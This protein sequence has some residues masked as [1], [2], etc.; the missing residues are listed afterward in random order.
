MKIDATITD[1]LARWEMQGYASDDILTI[2]G[3]QEEKPYYLEQYKAWVQSIQQR[4][5][6]AVG[7][8]YSPDPKGNEVY[9]VIAVAKHYADPELTIVVYF[10]MNDPECQTAQYAMLDD[11]ARRQYLIAWQK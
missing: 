6:P 8:L 3:M 1:A 7:E 4:S 5:T 11:F 2:F 9:C 10:D